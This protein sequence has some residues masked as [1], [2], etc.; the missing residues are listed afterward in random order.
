[1]KIVINFPKEGHPLDALPTFEDL[2]FKVPDELDFSRAQMK[3]KNG[4]TA[5]V[6]QGRHSYGGPEGLYEMAVMHGPEARIVYDT[7]VTSDVIGHCT[8]E[9]VT[10]VLR[11]IMKLP[12]RPE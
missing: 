2:S 3:F 7:P 5:S 8:T 10:R 4:Y 1:M 6:I 9:D 12:E 11:E